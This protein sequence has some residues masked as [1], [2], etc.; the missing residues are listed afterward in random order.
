MV[1]RSLSLGRSPADSCLIQL[2]GPAPALDPASTRRVLFPAR[3]SPPRRGPAAGGV[4]ALAS[5]I[6]L[7]G[8]NASAAISRE[9]TIY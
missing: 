7:A 1:R 4:F 9:R 2:A 8:G 6:G 3:S 5:A